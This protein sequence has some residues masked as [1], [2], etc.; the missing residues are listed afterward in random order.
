MA[1]DPALLPWRE[2]QVRTPPR[3][4]AGIAGRRQKARHLAD[5]DPGLTG[6]DLHRPVGAIQHVQH[7]Q[8]HRIDRRGERRGEV[9]L[10]HRGIAH[11]H[12]RRRPSLVSARGGITHGRRK[13]SFATGAS[14]ATPPVDPGNIFD[15]DFRRRCVLPFRKP[16]PHAVGQGSESLMGMARGEPMSDASEAAARADVFARQ[17]SA[18]R[19]PLAAYFRRRV[20]NPVEIEDLVQEVFLRLTVRGTPSN[21]DHASAYIFQI[22]ASVLA[23]RYRRRAVRHAD[24]HVVLDPS[25]R[26]E[27][28]F[29]PDRIYAG[30]QA[31]NAAAAALMTMPER[32]RT[33]FLLRRIDGLRHQAIATRLG[34]SISTV[35]KHMVRAI[36]HLMA[37][38]GDA[39]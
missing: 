5:E 21:T 7:G 10:V 16:A 11:R 32:T 6:I 18:M 27:H 9:R 1:H 24:G 30:K 39:R 12:L 17:A 29:D 38:A 35:E 20:R 36:E 37:H 31:L 3:R 8:R 33:I 23:D 22:A 25:L 28:D 19:G 26:D 14:R 2:R 4:E 15:E 34:L 13:P